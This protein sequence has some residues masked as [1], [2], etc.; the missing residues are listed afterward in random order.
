MFLGEIEEILD[1]IEPSQFRKI[2]EPLFKQISKCVANPHFQ[3]SERALYFWNN[4]YIVSLIEEHIENVL[5]IMFDCLFTISKEHWNPTIVA[6]IYNVMKAMMEMNLN[7]FDE[8]ATSYKEDKMRE[9]QKAQER[10]E[11]WR[12]LEELR[13][14]HAAS[15]QINSHGIPSFQNS[16]N[17]NNS[18]LDSSGDDDAVIHK[19]EKMCDDSEVIVGVLCTEEDLLQDIRNDSVL[20]NIEC[21]SCENIVVGEVSDIILDACVMRGD[22]AVTHKGDKMRG[23]SEVNIGVLRAEEDVD[24]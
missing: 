22:D 12:K 17:N 6:L 19:G 18:H 8:L 5:P 16:N 21:M 3:V 23:D 15:V 14:S 24:N 7:L 11:L 13:L 20:E 4:E 1:V 9:Q 10:D 2:Q